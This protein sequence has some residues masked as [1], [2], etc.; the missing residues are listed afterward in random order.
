MMT[1]PCSADGTSLHATSGKTT[2]EMLGAPPAHAAECHAPNASAA[3]LFASASETDLLAD[4]WK[5]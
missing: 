4:A 1:L 2:A 5:L 3:T